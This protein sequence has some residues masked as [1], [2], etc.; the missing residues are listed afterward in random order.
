MN[1]HPAPPLPTPAL[2]RWQPLRLGLVELFHYDSEEFWFHHG[3]LLLKGN[4][5]TG[6]SKV[7]SLTLPFLFDAQLKS[8]RIEPD[9]DATKKMAWNL[10]LGKHDRRIGYT[11]L[12][13]GRLDTEG[14]P[15]YLTLGC[16]LSANAARPQVDSWF[17]LLHD[18]RIGEDLWLMNP[19]RV[20]L[21]REH[22]REALQGDGQL[23]ET[24]GAYRRAVDEHLFGLGE[25]RYG[26]LMDTL[27]QLRQPQL[28]KRPDERS[29]SE[30][31]TEALPPLSEELLADVADALNRLEE[32]RRE[33]EEYEALA[34]SVDQFN[35][36][37]GRYAATQS[38][39]HARTLRSAQS[40]FDNASRA[41]NDS[42]TTLDQARQAEQQAQDRLQQ[43]L[44]SLSGHRMRLEALQNDP[45]MSDAKTL[46][47]AR[48]E[49]AQRQQDLDHAQQQLQQLKLRHEAE[50]QLL[51]QI[52]ER[53]D[54]ARAWMQTQQ[55]RL[56]PASETS[57]LRAAVDAHLP[58]LPGAG[59]TAT[60]AIT[61]TGEQLQAAAIRRHDHIRLMETRCHDMEDATREHQRA[62]SLHAQCADDVQT[63][64][65]ARERADAL[66]EHQCDT[67]L[68]DWQTYLDALQQLTI[69]DVEATLVPL[70]DWVRRLQGENPALQALLTA[71]QL[72]QQQQARRQS[73]LEGQEK[74]LHEEQTLLSTERQALEAGRQQA[75][76]RAPWRH[77]HPAGNQPG[78]PLWQLLDFKPSVSQADRA[79]LEAALEA[80]GLLDAWVQADGQ[81]RRAEDGTLLA[82]ELQWAS[83][84]VQATS[85]AD[86]LQ[87]ATEGIFTPSGHHDHASA[88]PAEVVQRLLQ[89]VHCSEEDASTREAWLSPSGAFRLGALVGRWQKPEAE[90]IGS[91]ARE[92]RRQRRLRE[93]DE[94]L[95]QIQA[96]QAEL[97][98]RRAHLEARQQQ[99]SREW[100]QVP[101]DLGLREAH[102]Q[103]T[104][105]IR[106]LEQA[107]LKADQAQEKLQAANTR[108]EGCRERL[109]T[110]AA[111]L[112]LPTTLEGLRACE[113]ALRTFAEALQ[114]WLLAAHRHQ[115][116]HED[117]DRQAQREAQARID[118]EESAA[119]QASRHQL[120]EQAR[121]QFQT[122]Q[123]SLGVRVQ[124][125]QQRL[126][127]ART[128]VSETEREEREQQAGLR[129]AGEQRARS[130]QQHEAAETLL[131]ERSQQRQHAIEQ[132]QRF[133]ATGLL[134][135][136]LPQLEQP[137]Q[138]TAWTI[139]PALNLARRTEQALVDIRDDDEAWSRIQ[140]QVSLDYTE[141]LRSLASLGQQAQSETT[142]FG[143]VVSIIYQNRPERPDQL[144][145]R[146]AGEIAIR[147][148]TL[149]ASEREV[150]ENHL[151]AEIASTI[152]RLLR[153]AEQQVQAI[154]EELDKRPTSTGVRFR[155]Q[156]E[157]LPEGDDDGAPV[158]LKT[159]RQHLLNTGADLWSAEDRQVVGDMLQG[160]IAAERNRSDAS[161]GSSLQEQLAR[162][163]DYRRWHRFR[164]QRWDGQWRPLSGPASSGERALGVTVPL[165]AAVSR[166]YSG[167][168][169]AHAPRLV[170]LDEVFAGIDDAARHH[171]WALIREFDLDFVVTSEREWAC[172]A[173][174]PG[175]AIAHLQRHQHIDAVHVSRWTWNGRSS[176][177]EPDPDRRFP[178]ERTRQPSD[179]DG[180]LM[181][182]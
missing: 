152:Q 159:A 122:L 158:G 146:L 8:S 101:S 2:S 123:E 115:S 174:L 69:P 34:R 100:Q 59:M 13:F 104:A 63:A 12:E 42:R 160:R 144:A 15:Q 14:K 148:E 165:F 102:Q 176:R 77:V 41:F 105:C 22:L 182:F 62:Q 86:W 92:A 48:N 37:Y 106:A 25:A 119:H 110:D 130:E 70:S 49:A 53:L 177:R 99:A 157:T 125:L 163:L 72:F 141:L 16:G 124:E 150:L 143:M 127:Q 137:A 164:V 138:D 32:Y 94:R 28:S 60:E 85:L 111:D 39:R 52:Q 114:A 117:H 103:A 169:H 156:W 45:G 129:I 44:E 167:A 38:R 18:R 40:A 121:I 3:R 154:N 180:T 170:L 57:G 175:V 87:P 65:E 140:S 181:A 76:P 134:A 35:R 90:F 10:L 23:F 43:L 172:S 1:D 20:V 88:V 98:T 26:A 67:L 178:P 74:S 64:S 81:L 21:T 147:R 132:W 30:A 168:H 9:G 162:A 66:V 5:G 55:A 109:D 50:R 155:L 179:A 46:E 145:S 149:T 133:A 83:R 151:Q 128:A 84:P 93:I 96:Q 54:Q 120:A 139:E 6:K 36:R 24:A 11:W 107:R 136:A 61:R 79:G 113:D 56:H 97:Q 131:A 7:L 91:A 71:M 80:S 126:K 78:A 95:Q 31:L 142:D 112:N 171:C 27:I 33:L 29:L 82:H 135:V 89:G 47:R 73:E 51:H 108:L 4:N 19:S 161:P 166:F 58:S 118:A 173:E 75:P 68:T 116:A 17:F 153:E